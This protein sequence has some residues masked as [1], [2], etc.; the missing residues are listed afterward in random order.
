[1]IEPDDQEDGAVSCKVVSSEN[2]DEVSNV[3]SENS[4]SGITWE[5]NNIL[6]VSP[7]SSICTLHECALKFVLLMDPSSSS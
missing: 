5:L 2:I 7:T 6:I 4:L 3:S 1:M